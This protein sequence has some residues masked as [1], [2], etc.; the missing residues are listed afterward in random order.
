MKP[1]KK[2]DFQN[3]LKNFKQEKSPAK[4]PAKQQIESTPYT[5]TK[6]PEQRTAAPVAKSPSATS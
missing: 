1:I 5:Y 2:A 4:Q 6:L 3:I